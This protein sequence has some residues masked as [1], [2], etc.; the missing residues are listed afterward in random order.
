MARLV[1]S[2]QR[3]WLHPETNSRNSA[4]QAQQPLGM[5]QF[6]ITQESGSTRFNRCT[7]NPAKALTTATSVEQPVTAFSVAVISS[8]RASLAMMRYSQRPMEP[9]RPMPSSPMSQDGSR[10]RILLSSHFLNAHLPL[11]VKERAQTL[12]LRLNIT[13]SIQVMKWQL[14]QSKAMQLGSVRKQDCKTQKHVEM[15][16]ILPISADHWSTMNRPQMQQTPWLP[17]AAS[18]IQ[19]TMAAKLSLLQLF[20]MVNSYMMKIE[21]R[22]SRRLFQL[23]TS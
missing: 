23:I 5:S 2:I 16:V 19:L 7:L 20:S 10:G 12:L 14:L 4:R 3:A 13:P 21:R 8:G 15:H 17:H 1:G 6:Q 18:C 11:W 22:R 9:L